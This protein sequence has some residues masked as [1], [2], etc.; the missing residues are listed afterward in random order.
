MVIFSVVN[1]SLVHE[2][3]KKKSKEERKTPFTN[4]K[5]SFKNTKFIETNFNQ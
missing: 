4:K 5:L 2:T 1:E 3:T